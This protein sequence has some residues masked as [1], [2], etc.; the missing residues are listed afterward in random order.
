MTGLRAVIVGAG[1]GGV[2]AAAALARNG[3]EVRV[4]EQARQLGE[5]GAGVV[6]APNSLRLLRRLG[7]GAEIARR[8]ARLADTQLCRA[9]GRPLAHDAGQFSRPGERYGM[10]RADLLAMLAGRLPGGVVRPG[11]RCTGLGQH[12]D[13]ATVSFAGGQRAAADVVIAADGIH[14]TLQGHVAEPSEPVFS[15]M[16]AYRGVIPAERMPSWPPG[17][18]RL[19]MGDGQHFLAYP[20]RAGQLLNYAGFVPSGRQTRESWSG[21]GDPA[22]LA[23]HFAGWDPVVAAIIAA[24]G[25]TG[26]RWGLYDRAP[27]RRWTRGRLAL[28]GDAAHPMLPYLAQGASQA[29]EDGA[30]LAAILAAADRPGVPSALLAYETLRRGRTARIQHDARQTGAIY[31]NSGTTP[32]SRHTR[33]G[34]RLP[35]RRWIYD[36]DIQAEAAPVAAALA[37]R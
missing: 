26:F 4:Y 36:Y 2:A 11:H 31:D 34:I 5:V 18:L 14:S 10:H 8:G 32:G 15:G 28:L 25:G 7:L 6:L 1:I 27:L 9:D 23:A 17:T 24:I 20:V 29:I 37:R 3:I 16:T 33:P 21:P 22:A 12:G 35:D 19:W 30:A 13:H